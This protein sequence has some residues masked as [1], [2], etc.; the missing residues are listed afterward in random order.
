[1]TLRRIAALCLVGLWPVLAGPAA[2]Q[3]LGR[4]VQASILLID[5]EQAFAQS[6]IGRRIA[7]EI[8]SASAELAAENRRIE[9]ELMEEEQRLTEQ[10]QT[11]PRDEFST[12]ATEFDEKVR[13]IRGEQ[14][15]KARAIGQRGD[16]GRREFLLAAQPVLEQ[17]MR[18]TGAVAIL[19]TRDVFLGAEAYNITE[20][21]IRRL[22][23]EAAAPEEGEA[24]DP[25][26]SAGETAPEQ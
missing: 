7:D 8:E 11:L 3:Q 21:V 2:A 9:A 26:A 15:A 5:S 10:R 1:M 22:D 14:E 17:I 25:G 18:E 13:R 12:L 20:E 16:A 19:E 24:T 4:P 6:R 23:A